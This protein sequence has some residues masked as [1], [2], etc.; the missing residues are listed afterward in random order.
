MIR[1]CVLI[2]FVVSI[3]AQYMAAEPDEQMDNH[4]VRIGPELAAQ[5][6]I[7][8]AKAVESQATAAPIHAPGWIAH[9]PD[10]T[11]IVGTAVGGRVAIVHVA[12]GA[13]VAAGDPLI[14]IESPELGR[15]QSD[16]LQKRALVE[17][18]RARADIAELAGRRAADLAKDQAIP[19]AE[20][21]RRELESRQAQA[22]LASARSD[23]QTAE[24]ALVLSGMDDAA[25][26]ALAETGAISP[27][28]VIHA[29]IAGI[30]VSRDAVRGQMVSPETPSLLTIADTTSVWVLANVP[31]AQAPA[32]KPGAAA[33]IR[34]QAL[35]D[36]SIKTTVAHVAA[37]VD[38]ATRSVQIRC[39]VKGSAAMKAGAFVDVEITP[40]S[41]KAALV[42]PR[43]A[44]FSIDGGSAV[45]MP[46]PGGAGV[47]TA[48]AIETGRA[49]GDN[50]PVLDGLAAGDEVVVKGGF[51]L[52][53]EL[54]KSGAKGC[55]DND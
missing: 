7:V 45:F 3:C 19:V 2:A 43:D 40:E 10:A 50:V 32:V 47:Y 6:G 8:V 9:D 37:T 41:P 27:R 29:P 49:A 4:I 38:A 55:C 34:S 24:H 22:E 21:G 15:V 51:I 1:Q 30:V 52:K 16:F 31:E 26:K 54:L 36:R 44:V 14:E 13:T 28:V 17:V 33:R 11:A 23:L 53:A 46:M 12:A 18:A 42:V 48:H 20:A 39:V 35:G 25:R 5:H